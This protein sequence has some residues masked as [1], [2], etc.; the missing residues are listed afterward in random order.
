MDLEKLIENSIEKQ[1]KETGI[2]NS[3]IF[4]DEFKKQF[5]E[6]LE[7]NDSPDNF[8]KLFSNLLNKGTE[9]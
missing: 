5:K 2:E 7:G 1:K 8:I 4:T 9:K 3:H 6:I